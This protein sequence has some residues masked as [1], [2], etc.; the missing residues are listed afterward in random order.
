MA[1]AKIAETLPFTQ[2]RIGTSVYLGLPLFYAITGC[3]TIAYFLGCGKETARI[4]LKN[5]PGEIDML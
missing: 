5:T 1:L 2:F 4:A 3:D